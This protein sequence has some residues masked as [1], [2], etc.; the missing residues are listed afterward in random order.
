MA[1][2]RTLTQEEA[3]RFFK[4]WGV[5]D[6]ESL[7]RLESDPKKF[8][9][10]REKELLEGSNKVIT[11]ED[12]C[13]TYIAEAKVYLAQKL[14]GC[15]DPPWFKE[16]GAIDDVIK[17][18]IGEDHPCFVEVQLEFYTR[19]CDW[20]CGLY[21]QD[22]EHCS[23]KIQDLRQ[24]VY[25]ESIAMLSSK[26]SA[27]FLL[28]GFAANNFRRFKLVCAQKLRWRRLPGGEFPLIDSLIMGRAGYY[29]CSF[30]PDF[31]ER[32]RFL[33]HDGQI[34]GWY[35][36]YG[37]DALGHAENISILAHWLE[38]KGV[39]YE[40]FFEQCCSPDELAA[41]NLMA[42][43]LQVHAWFVQFHELPSL[44]DSYNPGNMFSMIYP[45][46]PL[47][48]PGFMSITPY[49]IQTPKGDNWRKT[50]L[51]GVD[52][53]LW[54][55]E[56]CPERP[57]ESPLPHKVIVNQ[58]LLGWRSQFCYQGVQFLGRGD[59]GRYLHALESDLRYFKPVD[60]KRSPRFLEKVLTRLYV[61]AQQSDANSSAQSFAS[62]EKNAYAL[63]ERVMRVLECSAQGHKKLFLTVPYSVWFLMVTAYVDR[64]RK[65][66]AVTDLR[67]R[68]TGDECECCLQ[69]DV[70]IIEDFKGRSLWS[71]IGWLFRQT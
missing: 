42:M 66:R 48:D 31:E 13:K 50:R 70:R 27:Q 9:A 49:F 35:G 64:L 53:V 16:P 19:A 45:S 14:E 15:E 34:F 10:E 21:K 69:D 8:W 33:V 11:H 25:D 5:R 43:T 23:K 68:S 38:R 62:F 3:D 52:W 12:F 41:G 18:Y 67:I 32:T 56:F 24:D 46:S 22:M 4:V 30:S 65:V 57:K 71:V 28:A 17:Q 39:S 20:V 44:K 51:K 26:L 7:M 1:C 54:R 2:V 36:V 61:L 60:L 47:M 55:A 59:F 29:M 40:S 37:H 58:Y 63:T 6:M